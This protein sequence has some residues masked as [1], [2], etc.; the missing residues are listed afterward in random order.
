M[1]V[2]R[3]AILDVVLLT[4]KRY[5]DERGWLSEVYSR[6]AM[7][8]AGVPMEFVQDNQAFSPKRGTLR[9]LWRG[10]F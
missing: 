4:P 3:L 8:Q 9:G 7:A 2:E 1:Q 5:G 6:R 10:A